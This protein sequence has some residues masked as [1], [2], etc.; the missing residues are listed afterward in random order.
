VRIKLESCLDS[1]GLIVLTCVGF[2]GFTQRFPGFCRKLGNRNVVSLKM[3]IRAYNSAKHAAWGQSVM[4]SR[5]DGY[6]ERQ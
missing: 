2:F 1:S 4:V 5:D 3:I 6:F